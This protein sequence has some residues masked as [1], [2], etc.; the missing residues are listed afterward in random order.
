VVAYA[1]FFA[2]GAFYFGTTTAMLTI[3]QSRVEDSIRGRVMSLW[4]MA[5]GGMVA[6]C[7]PIFGPLLDATGP[8]LVLAI[9]AVSAAGLAWTC[10][11]RAPVD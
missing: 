10:D 2:L 5:F 11:L 6:L 4:F 7:G 1:A 3:L 9:S 8:R